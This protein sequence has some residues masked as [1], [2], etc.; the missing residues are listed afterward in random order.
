M[1]H[2]QDPPEPS[3]IDEEG[4]PHYITP[5]GLPPNN[6]IPPAPDPTPAPA[7]APTSDA[8]LP[9]PL[10][11]PGF[12]I[13]PP[14]S[15]SGP[16]APFYLEDGRAYFV[17]SDGFLAS[18][19]LPP[20]TTNGSLPLTPIPENG[21]A[22]PARLPQWIPLIRPMHNSSFRPTP[23]PSGPPPL[24]YIHINF[25]RDG[26]RPHRDLFTGRDRDAA[27]PYTLCQVATYTRMDDLIRTMGTGQMAGITECG[28]PTNDRRPWTEVKTFTIGD[29]ESHRSLEELGWT[30]AR[31]PAIRPIWVCMYSEELEREEERRY[32]E[33]LGYA[34]R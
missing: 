14:P 1:P 23:A 21:V 20:P 19:L 5:D 2:R 33:R 30:D 29:G 28:L 22:P 12:A 24:K 17:N 6:A 26:I 27:I 8:A 18:S 15:N 7:P 4:R 31:G 10:N 34:T 3:F 11:P 32:W 25:I 13:Y 16:P 9:R